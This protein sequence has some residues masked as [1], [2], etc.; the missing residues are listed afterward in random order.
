MIVPLRS[1]L[2]SQS[3]N[4][5]NTFPGERVHAASERSSWVPHNPAAAPTHQ[6]LQWLPPAAHTVPIA[7][8]QNA[9]GAAC[10]HAH[11]WHDHLRTPAD[12]ALLQGGRCELPR[13]ERAYANPCPCCRQC[14]RQHRQ[15]LTWPDP[16]DGCWLLRPASRSHRHRNQTRRKNRNST[17][18]PPITANGKYFLS[19]A[20]TTHRTRSIPCHHHLADSTYESSASA[21]CRQP[22]KNPAPGCHTCRWRSFALLAY[23]FDSAVKVFDICV[24]PAAT[25]AWLCCTPHFIAITTTA[26]GSKPCLYSN[27]WQSSTGTKSALSS[28]SPCSS[29][30]W[31]LRVMIECTCRG[32]SPQL[33]GPCCCSLGGL[34]HVRCRSACRGLGTHTADAG[35]R[36]MRTSAM[37]AFSFAMLRCVRVSMYSFFVFWMNVS[38]VNQTFHIRHEYL[39][40]QKDLASPFTVQ[41]TP[42]THFKHLHMY[43]VC[44]HRTVSAKSPP[45]LMNAYGRATAST[46]EPYS[47]PNSFASSSR[48]SYASF[49]G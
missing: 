39:Q 15:T 13:A 12:W 47:R 29:T 3:G 45:N 8:L 20:C 21:G 42:W 48:Y 34:P 30:S 11:D 31:M 18:M 35:H 37:S 14:R 5:H 44:L 6:G 43:S 19:I 38:V 9:A 1:F 49:R 41:C 25:R 33:G 16:A 4:H 7:T 28:R 24:I 23:C 2:A 17:T 26:L 27:K 40:C 10:C 32:Q 46:C 36:L 22:F